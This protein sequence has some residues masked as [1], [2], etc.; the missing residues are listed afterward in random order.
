M[1]TKLKDVKKEVVISEI[2]DVLSIVLYL[3]VSL[4]LVATVKGLIL[5]QVG[6]N[7]FV[8]LYSVA[9]IEAVVLGKVVALTQKLPIMNAWDRHPLIWVILYKSAIMTVIIDI[10]NAIEDKIFVHSASQHAPL[11]PVIF[12]F[13]HQALELLVFI[14][15]YSVRGLDRKLGPGKLMKLLIANN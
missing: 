2:K 10:A 8:H 13:A 14:V 4:S 15:L 5:I 9:I 1:L 7:E 12:L 11:H 6:I 3:T